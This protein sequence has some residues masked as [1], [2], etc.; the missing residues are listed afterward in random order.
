MHNKLFFKI[1]SADL[2]IFCLKNRN[3]C[4]PRYEARFCQQNSISKKNKKTAKKCLTNY[5]LRLAQRIWINLGT[6]IEKKC[7]LRYEASFCQ[8]NV[9]NLK[10]NKKNAQ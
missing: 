4:S 6:K 8:K 9:S 5:F 3:K 2:E 1:G 7:S 10:K